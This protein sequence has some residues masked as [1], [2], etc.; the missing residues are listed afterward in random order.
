MNGA[1]RDELLM[2]LGRVKENERGEVVIRM[3]NAAEDGQLMRN[4]G[5]S[6]VSREM[7][8]GESVRLTTLVV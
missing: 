6:H 3:Q 7:R 8:R 1:K 4:K 2:K 5:Q